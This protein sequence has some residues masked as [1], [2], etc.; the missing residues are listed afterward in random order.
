MID[1][2]IVINGSKFDST[3]SPH[4]TPVTYLLHSHE[5]GY[6]FISKVNA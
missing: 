6:V 2:A 3:I 1:N 5:H 4:L